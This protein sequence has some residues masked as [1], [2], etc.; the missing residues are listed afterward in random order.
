ML[1]DIN[2]FFYALGHG[3]ESL[4][5]YTLI[6]ISGVFNFLVI[7]LGFFGL[8]FWLWKQGKYNKQAKDN[9]DQIK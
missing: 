6:P 9:K 2:S 3:L 8:F 4:F 7:C 5:E 1:A